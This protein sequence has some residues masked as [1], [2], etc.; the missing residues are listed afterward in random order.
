MTI[1][2]IDIIE[3][4]Q[5]SPS[6]TSI[7]ASLKDFSDK[8]PPCKSETIH[9]RRRPVGS[10]SLQ[11][12]EMSSPEQPQLS[13]PD[14]PQFNIA[15]VPTYLVNEAKVTEIKRYT[16]NTLFKTK[17]KILQLYKEFQQ[18]KDLK[19]ELLSIAQ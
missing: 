19:T 10:P 9:G 17:A 1:G 5:E 3:E 14:S 8:Q 2:E 4:D 12:M 18:I 15:P 6:K 11:S 16:A 13:R 7:H